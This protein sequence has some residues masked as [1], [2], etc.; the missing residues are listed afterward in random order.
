M[1]KTCT[2]LLGFLREPKPRTAV[3]IFN[4]DGWGP[5][6]LLPK[7]HSGSQQTVWSVLCLP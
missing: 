5:N 7:H 1:V 3:S 2:N 4:K 6:G